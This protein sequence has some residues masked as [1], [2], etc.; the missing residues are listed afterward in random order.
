VSAATLTN[1]SG[2]SISVAAA[3]VYDV[4]A[5]IAY[6]QSVANAVGFG[7]TFPG[8]T[9]ATGD[10]IGNVSVGPVAVSSF[11]IL[12][13]GT[14]DEAGS[15]SIIYSVSATTNTRHVRM[16]ALFIVSSSGGTI[17]MQGRVSAAAAQLFILRGSYIKAFKIG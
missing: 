14:F 12:Q 15:G 11:S 16:R 8:M 5:F 2:L 13:Y 10:F 7:V 3:G 6:T 9:A 17:Q 1:L 4:E